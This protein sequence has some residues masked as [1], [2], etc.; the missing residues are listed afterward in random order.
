MDR[1]QM[2]ASENRGRPLEGAGGPALH[3][4]DLQ[5]VSRLVRDGTHGPGFRRLQL[6]VGT[7]IPRLEGPGR[8]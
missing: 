3:R 6:M 7:I 2:E 4:I 5:Q 8:D 1:D